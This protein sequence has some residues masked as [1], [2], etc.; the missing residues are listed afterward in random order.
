MSFNT[1]ESMSEKLLEALNLV[2]SPTNDYTKIS[3]KITDNNVSKSES[4]IR[5][6]LNGGWV[7]ENSVITAVNIVNYAIDKNSREIN[8]RL[9]IDSIL[10][11]YQIK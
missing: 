8:S 4:T 3:A 2:L 5:N 7:K 6:L 9:H 10:K 1:N 11:Q